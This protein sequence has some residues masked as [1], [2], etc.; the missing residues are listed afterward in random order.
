M[1]AKDKSFTLPS[2]IMCAVFLA[3]A[4]CLGAP[5]KKEKAESLWKQGFLEYQ[6]RRYKSAI[7]YFDSSLAVDP[8]FYKAYNGKGICLAFLG[9]TTEGIKYIDKSLQLNKDYENGYFNK[10]LAQELAGNYLGAIT[11]FKSALKIIPTNPWSYYGIACSYGRL[12]D[13]KHAA[14]ALKKAIA[15][16]P[17]TRT[18][19]KS[20]KDLEK[21]KNDPNIRALLKTP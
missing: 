6:Q 20:E 9:D 3:A 10:A 5:S 12:G 17:S 13:A 11:S 19:A 14:S 7:T 8:S 4:S 16:D 18:H 2:I 1:I 15:I 21:V